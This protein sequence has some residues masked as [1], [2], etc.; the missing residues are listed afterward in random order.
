[1][2]QDMDQCRVAMDIGSQKRRRLF[3]WQRNFK[4]VRR[5]SDKWTALVRL[6][7]N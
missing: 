2:A 4:S 7:V 5:G 6:L 1:M 3:E